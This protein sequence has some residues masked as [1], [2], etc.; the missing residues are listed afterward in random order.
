MSRLFFVALLI[1]LPAAIAKADD[2]TNATTQKSMNE[3]ARKAYEKS[4][5]EL[6]KLYR[7]I[8]RRLKGEPDTK[9][10]LVKTQRAWVN[11]RDAECKF[12]TSNALGG[13]IYPLM[14]FICLE[15]LTRKRV[16]D[17]KDYLDCSEG[18]ESCPVPSE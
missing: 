8:T 2:C 11:F 16:G 5:A 3:C 7:Q 14:Y 12:A 6:N 13:S 10:R 1:L 4:D 15:H 9:E 17:F 18:A